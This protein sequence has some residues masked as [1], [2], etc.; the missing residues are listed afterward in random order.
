MFL[1]SQ[2]IFHLLSHKYAL[3]RWE[4]ATADVPVRMAILYRG[5]T[6]EPGRLYLLD[7]LTDFTSVH[8]VEGC[9]FLI[10]SSAPMNLPEP[11]TKADAAFV[12]D[13]ISKLDL[14]DEVNDLISALL[15]WDLSLRDACAAKRKRSCLP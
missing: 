13:G 6:L 15:E 8:P 3:H 4:S 5:Q 1:T 2:M 14:F 10:L 9:A 7:E 12:T 11:Y